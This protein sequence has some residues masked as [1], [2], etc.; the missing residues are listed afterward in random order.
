MNK[1]RYLAELGRLLIFMTAADRDE[2]LHRFGALFDEAGPDGAEAL[3]S[4]IGSP[5]KN[6]I[7]LSRVYE[8]GELTDELLFGDVPPAAPAPRPAPAAPAKAPSEQT[9]RPDEFPDFGLPDLPEGPQ[10][11]E[12]ATEGAPAEDTPAAMQPPEKAQAPAEPR[13]VSVPIHDGEPEEEYGPQRPAVD[14][15]MPLW[16]GVPLFILAVIVLG[17]PLAVIA[18]A[19]LPVMLLPGAAILIGAVLAAVG[20][21]WCISYIADAVMLFGVAFFVLGLAL[22]ILWCGVWLDVAIVK[23]YIRIMVGLKHLFLGRR[24]S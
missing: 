9:K 23:I 6:A 16:L 10:A 1:Q 14:R 7:R 19:L 2:T 17:V 5:T 21:L 11:P 20:G 13:F 24:A 8:P 18:L 15:P 22:V 3:V 4:R 12:K